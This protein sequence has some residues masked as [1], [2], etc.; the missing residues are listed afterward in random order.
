MGFV[1]PILRS[2]RLDINPAEV[3]M[4]DPPWP[5]LT[6]EVFGRPHYFEMGEVVPQDFLR[7]DSKRGKTFKL[8]RRRSYLC[9]TRWKP[10]SRRKWPN[11][12]QFG[13]DHFPLC[14]ITR[15]MTRSGTC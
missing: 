12:T 4:L 15:E 9:G 1:H 7:A 2:R 8:N 5:D 13:P 10:S 14:F 3:E 6:V 11:G